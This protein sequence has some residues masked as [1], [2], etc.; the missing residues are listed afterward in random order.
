MIRKSITP[1]KI[2]NAV[3]LEVAFFVYSVATVFSKLASMQEF[4]SFK[5]IL[6]AAALVV[7]LGIYALLWQQVLKG[8]KLV[9]AMSNKGIV[10]I[11][12]LIWSALLF[13][14]VIMLEN[15]IGGVLIIAGILV[16]SKNEA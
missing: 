14:E 4:F 2:K 10:V 11:W 7:G 15:L 16:V 3:L 9:T 1:D 6:F 5:F 12:N 13:K 8:F